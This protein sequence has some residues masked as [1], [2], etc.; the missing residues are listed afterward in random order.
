MRD[1]PA[2]WVPPCIPRRALE[3]TRL[4]AG[5]ARPHR[6]EDVMGT[7]VL[8]AGATGAIGTRL[9]PLLLQGSA[10]VFGTTRAAAR[11]DEL[12]S[13]GIEPIVVDVFDAPALTRAMVA[14]APEVVVHQLT[15]LALI[16]TQSRL[17]EAL[18]R[19]ARRR[20]E[21]THNLVAAALE[22]GAR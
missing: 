11:A 8:L 12:R 18:T 4:E 6:E 14:V 1:G 3:H 9:L 19:N 16:H 7:R 22:A 2:V 10:V 17:V 5:S 13:R 21:G 15:D 20:T